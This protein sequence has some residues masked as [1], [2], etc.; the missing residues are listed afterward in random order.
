MEASHNQYLEPMS[1][2][3]RLRYEGAHLV[4][5]HLMTLDR[6]A[7]EVIPT[8]SEYYKPPVIEGT[9][10]AQQQLTQAMDL[11]RCADEQL[12]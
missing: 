9:D 11:Y 2:K 6:F 10:L 1:R 3:H 12:L 5:Q 7:G 8:Q 4:I